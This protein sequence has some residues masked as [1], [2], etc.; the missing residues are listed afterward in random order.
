MNLPEL[1][2]PI[3]FPYALSALPETLDTQWDSPSFLPY[4]SAFPLQHASTP[5]ALI[6]HVRD[7]MAQDL[8]IPYLKSLQG[9]LWLRGYESGELRCPLFPDVY[10]A[11]KKW[12]EDGAKI[13]IYSSGSVAAQK[14]LWRYTTEGDL[15][16]LIWNGVHGDDA[17]ETEGGYWD[18]VNAGLK[19]NKES[20]E[21]IAKANRAL[22]EVGEWLFLSDNVKE[23]MAAK[24]GGMKSLVV[25]REGNAVISAEESWGQVLVESF[26]EV[27][28]WVEVVGGDGGLRQRR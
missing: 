4:R 27:E 14:L 28:R 6:S 3:H 23:V 12:E 5:E 8:K 10:P 24:E 22:G 1:P 16:G 19:Q 7:L 17:V 20:Y 15:R 21:K 13:C 11:M 9:Y 26:G 18:T 2:S 25:V